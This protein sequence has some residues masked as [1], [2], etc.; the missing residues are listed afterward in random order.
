[1]IASTSFW[2]APTRILPELYRVIP[3]SGWL[4]G[5]NRNTRN[6]KQIRKQSNSKDNSPRMIE[7][8]GTNGR[9]IRI[10][11]HLVYTATSPPYNFVTLTFLG[12]N[13]AGAHCEPQWLGT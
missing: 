2:V 10:S 6:P 5:H 8:L 3:G 11:T 13:A 1:M 12:S 9:R 4:I 7:I